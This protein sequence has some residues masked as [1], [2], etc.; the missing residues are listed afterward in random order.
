MLALSGVWFC[1]RSK[2]EEL[3]VRRS[4]ISVPVEA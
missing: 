4:L 1:I 2:P 3:R